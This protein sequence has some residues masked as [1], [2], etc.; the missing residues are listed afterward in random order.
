[1]YIYIYIYIYIINIYINNKRNV[2]WVDLV[3]SFKKVVI[4]KL[5]N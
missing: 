1:V 3:L 2:I 5:V 4:L